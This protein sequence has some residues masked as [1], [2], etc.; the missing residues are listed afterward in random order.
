MLLIKIDQKLVYLDIYR[1]QSKAVA[2]TLNL[3]LQINLIDT[4]IYYLNSIEFHN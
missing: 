2:K 4:Q 1:L 3:I